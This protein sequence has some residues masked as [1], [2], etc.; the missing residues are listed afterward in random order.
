[1]YGFI[2]GLLLGAGV[3]GHALR[4][5]TLNPEEYVSLD[6]PFGDDGR[7]TERARRFIAWSAIVVYGLGSVLCA[8]H[9]VGGPII[10]IVFP[11]VGVTAVLT[12]AKTKLDT[13]QIVLGVFQSLA[14]A[15]SVAA[16]LA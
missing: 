3:G 8:L 2:G 9:N 15:L 5:V 16:L 14:A 12:V 11:V 6:G 10:A 13:F 7:R 1:M 4:L